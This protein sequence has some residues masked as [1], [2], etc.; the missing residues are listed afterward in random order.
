LISWSVDVVQWLSGCCAVVEWMLCIRSLDVVPTCSFEREKGDYNKKSKFLNV[1]QRKNLHQACSFQI[2]SGVFLQLFL[3]T[4][5][6][7]CCFFFLRLRL[8]CSLFWRKL[9]NLEDVAW[10]IF[11]LRVCG[12]HGLL[13]NAPT[14]GSG[15][16]DAL[17]GPVRSRTF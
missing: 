12:E 9:C 14:L 8:L 3:A 13:A 1:G 7:C 17:A 6:C 5:L 11:L 10:F 2:R 4:L 15:C 16:C